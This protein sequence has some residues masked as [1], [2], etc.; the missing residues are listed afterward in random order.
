M[1]L[2]V[3]CVVQLQGHEFNPRHL[4][5]K[6]HVCYSR[7]MTSDLGDRERRTLSNPRIRDLRDPVTH[8]KEKILQNKRIKKRTNN[9][10]Q[11]EKITKK[12]GVKV[13]I[14]CQLDRNQNPPVGERQTFGYT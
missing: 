12:N 8:K 9:K 5:K 1:P 6:C 10:R 2:L 7:V 3:K 11:T 4:N 13:N 14:N